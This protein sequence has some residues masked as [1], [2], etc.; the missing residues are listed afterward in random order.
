M[1]DRQGKEIMVKSATKQPMAFD[2]STALHEP[3]VQ[4]PMGKQ[5]NAKSCV[6]GAWFSP[7]SG[8]TIP[9]PACLFISSKSA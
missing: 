2:E 5:A 4:R 1:T 3:L 9:H 6:M 7:F 8:H